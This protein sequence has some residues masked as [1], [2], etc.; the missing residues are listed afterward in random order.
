MVFGVLVSSILLISFETDELAIKAMSI[1]QSSL[2]GLI[3]ETNKD[4]YYVMWESKPLLLCYQINKKVPS[5]LAG[6]PQ[7]HT[8]LMI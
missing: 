1:T 3:V 4:C 8:R 5:L 7:P 2:R 6:F